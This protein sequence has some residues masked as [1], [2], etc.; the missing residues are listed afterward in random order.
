MINKRIVLSVITL[1]L[2]MIIITIS[3]PNMIFS[4]DGNIKSFGCGKNKTI[5]SLGV[6]TLFISICSFYMFTLIDNV[7]D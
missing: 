3:K 6:I 5:Y 7:M 1:I 2:I 4:N